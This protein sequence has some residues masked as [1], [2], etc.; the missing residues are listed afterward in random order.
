MEDAAEA[1]AV[2]EEA[3][4]VTDGSIGLLAAGLV[5]VVHVEHHLPAARGGGGGR[6]RLAG[7]A[8]SAFFGCHHHGARTRSRA[9]AWATITYGDLKA[10]HALVVGGT[11]IRPSARGRTWLRPPVRL[12]LTRAVTNRFL[13]QRKRRGKTA[14]L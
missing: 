12:R 7:G 9:P 8:S 11:R 1:D 3:V 13:V 2:L 10:S 14:V 4:D 5:H 6:R